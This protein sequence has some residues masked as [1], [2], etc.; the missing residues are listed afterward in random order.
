MGESIGLLKVI[1]VEGK[2]LAIRDFIS[3]DPYVI[4]RVGEL[5]IK[6]PLTK[7][8]GWFNFAFSLEACTNFPSFIQN[9]MEKTKVIKRSL[10]PVWNEE[11]TFSIKGPVTDLK[12]E[13]FDHDRFKFD[14]KMGHAYLSLQPIMSA[15]KLKRALKLSTGESETNLRKVAPN[16]DNCLI[17]DSSVT[18]VNGEIVQDV[19][20][21]LQD[22]ESGEL[23]VK[24]KWFDL[25]T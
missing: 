6:W 13:V 21:K 14:D 1:I 11:L 25:S 7:T 23:F 24:L 10:N 20:L 9:P 18:Y 16:R 19:Y 5:Q 12:L 15:S 4:V 3:S 2:R 8:M 22:V 17:V